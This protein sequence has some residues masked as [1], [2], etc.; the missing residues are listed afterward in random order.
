MF[1]TLALSTL[2]H[3][4]S[5][6]K[7]LAALK[8]ADAAGLAGAFDALA[9][10]DKTTAESSFTD[11][12]SKADDTDAL[13]AF[14]RVA[15]TREVWKPMWTA[16]G[17]ISNYDARD[18][19]AQRVGE[20]CGDDP[21]IVPFLQG[22]YLGLRDIEFQQW[23][24][25]FVA[26]G[27][28]ALWTWM[29]EKVAAPPSKRFDEK[30]NNLMAI[31]VKKKRA[32]ALGALATAAVKAA[33]AGPYDAVLFK[34]GEAVAPD[35]GG[36]IAP[37]DQAKFEAALVD[38]ASKVSTDKARA[39]ADQLANSGSDA[40]AAKLLPVL[41]GDRMSAGNFTYGAATIEAGDC[42]GKKE[43]VIHWASVSEPGKRWSI[44]KD[45]EVPMR[46]GSKAK[47]K[48]CTVEGEWPVM[49]TPE[50]VA[51][52]GDVDDWVESLEK[53]W[54]GKGYD[55]KTSKEKSVTLP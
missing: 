14:A 35:M 43:A 53:D 51:S 46:S 16:L 36:N 13:V 24:D 23:D 39:V 50:P 8:S 47:L 28:T 38:V 41:Y 42:G 37:D 26:C 20:A 10:C 9:A 15:I 11:A 27:D 55:V 44:L 21:K 17:K 22:A 49:H 7:Q 33:E 40:A 6:D 31:Y 54:A 45:L 4:A 2:A 29:D 3:A 52:G 18:E 30:Y 12:L 19:V 32:D 34:M 1:L 25:A 48:G 5:C